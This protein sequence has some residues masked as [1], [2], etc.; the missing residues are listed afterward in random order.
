MEAGSFRIDLLRDGNARL[1]ISLNES[2][3]Q[4]GISFDAVIN[5][6]DEAGSELV[7]SYLGSVDGR[8]GKLVIN[9]VIS[10]QSSGKI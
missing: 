1:T 3:R 6:R 5:T 4:E 2:Y 10:S 7:F 8:S 9:P